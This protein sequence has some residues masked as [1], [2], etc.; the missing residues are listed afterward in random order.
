MNMGKNQPDH[1]F[2]D[3][4]RIAK[5]IRE[6]LKSGGPP[7]DFAA[8]H[9]YIAGDLG[10]ADSRRVSERIVTWQAWYRAY[11]E[12]MFLLTPE[13]AAS[14]G[15]D[16]ISEHPGNETIGVPT[17]PVTAK[18]WFASSSIPS[19]LFGVDRTGL[20]RWLVVA[21]VATILMALGLV[22]WSSSRH[23][24]QLAFELKDGK[25]VGGTR[26]EWQPRWFRFPAGRMAK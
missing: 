7:V 18:R 15:R 25:E 16:S 23:G 19:R 11:W 13:K 14:Q 22:L 1:P 17:A 20:W 4:E 3:F 26:Y 8:I 9:L 12:T 6:Q 10:E 5:E 21:T 2:P 24:P